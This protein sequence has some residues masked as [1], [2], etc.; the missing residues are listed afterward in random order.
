MNLKLIGLILVTLF[1]T[2]CSGSA[3]VG[4]SASSNEGS[5]ISA[6]YVCQNVGDIVVGY[7]E[8]LTYWRNTTN[9]VPYDD[10]FSF[11]SDAVLNLQEIADQISREGINWDSGAIVSSFILNIAANID[12]ISTSTQ[13]RFFPPGRDLNALL[14][15]IGLNAN[16][17]LNSA[18]K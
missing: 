15:D 16:S 9:N 7:D 10:L 5:G 13:N 2:G 18:C 8:Y 1:I 17:V 6:N 12:E 11:S 4:D 14:Q 3:T